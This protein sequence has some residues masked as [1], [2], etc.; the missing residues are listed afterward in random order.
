MQKDKCAV[1]EEMYAENERK[2]EEV[3]DQHAFEAIKWHL[4]AS[5]ACSECASI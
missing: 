4:R 3:W 2:M 5:A 1:L